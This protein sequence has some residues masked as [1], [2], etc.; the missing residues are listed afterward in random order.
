MGDFEN[1]L[2]LHIFI[3]SSFYYIISNDGIV[4]RSF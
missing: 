1:I 3:L 4:A 2:G